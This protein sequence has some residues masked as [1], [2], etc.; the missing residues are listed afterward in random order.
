MLS[1]ADSE[2]PEEPEESEL[3]EESPSSPSRSSK[4]LCTCSGSTVTTDCSPS[5][6]VPSMLVTGMVW[7]VTLPPERFC[8]WVARFMMSQPESIVTELSIAL[9]SL[10]SIPWSVRVFE[11]RILFDRLAR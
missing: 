4:N 9:L 2:D 1:S 3:S 6:L 10:S 5:S 11:L 7:K 8:I